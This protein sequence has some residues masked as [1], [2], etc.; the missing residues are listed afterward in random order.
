[1][2][3]E[4]TPSPA[5]SRPSGDFA[6]HL[7]RS[8]TPGQPQAPG[9]LD[10]IGRMARGLSADDRRSARAMRRAR[11]GGLD[12]SQL[13]ALQSDVYRYTQQMELT[14]KVVDKAAQAVKTTLQSQQ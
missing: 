6:A 8:E 1:M 3:L 14:S 2:R 11:R 12:P 4:P 7:D 9:F 13:L 10:M 5:P